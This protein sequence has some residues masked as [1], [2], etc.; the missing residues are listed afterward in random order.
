MLLYNEPGTSLT[1]H[2]A[3]G[4]PR[5]AFIFRGRDDFD[6]RDPDHARPLVE[7]TCAGGGWLTNQTLQEWA[8]AKE[9][10]FD[11]VTRVDVRQW[12]AGRVVLLGD[13]ASCISLS[14]D[15]SSSAIVGA[16]ALAGAIATHSD[17][18]SAAFA[19]HEYTHRKYVRPLQRGAGIAS[20][21]LVPK[22][23]T[24]IAARIAILNTPPLR[25]KR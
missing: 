19:D 1:I 11:A 23:R 17:N 18:H 6:Y 13:A 10:Y 2:P 25:N 8:A 15:C 12:S 7:S 16:K 4:R 21:L 24:G 20:L 22:S 14:G 9:R 5:F 3:G